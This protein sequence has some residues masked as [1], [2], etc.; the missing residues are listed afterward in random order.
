MC[1]ERRKSRATVK[2]RITVMESIPITSI[3]RHLFYWIVIF[4][5]LSSSPLV[6]R[7]NPETPI[8]RVDPLALLSGT[9]RTYQRAGCDRELVTLSCPRG[10]SISIEVAQYGQSNDANEQSLCPAS[11]D[12]SI[13]IS[14]PGTEIEI[15][16]P[17]SC[18][19]PNAL[20]V[21]Q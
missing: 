9:L 18:T 1:C 17:E 7:A 5:L 4:L 13:E 15:K 2:T 10:T 14:L 3:H 8:Y 21:S 11:T 16:A 19:W 12:D 20:Q 6:L